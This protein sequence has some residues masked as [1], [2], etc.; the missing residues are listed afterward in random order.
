MFFSRPKKEEQPSPASAPVKQAAPTTASK[1]SAPVDPDDFF[2]DMGRKSE[3][4]AP[5]P[6]PAAASAPAASP[7]AVK[8]SAPAD[9][10]DFFKDMGRRPKQPKPVEAT[11]DVPEVTGLREAPEP[12]LPSNMVNLSTSELSTSELRDKRAEDDGAYHGNMNNVDESTIDISV[13]ERRPAPAAEPAPK[14]ADEPQ[15]FSSPDDF[16]K[17]MGRKAKPKEV[18]VNIESPVI[19]GLREAPEP[20]LP[21]YMNDLN[22]DTLRTDSLRDG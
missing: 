3:P 14:P 11:V 9:P 21:S 2:K 8:P 19:T 22:T 17:D 18:E 13:L 4:K 6:T 7:S 12:V 1:P 16:F 20:V 5:A 10:D 15:G